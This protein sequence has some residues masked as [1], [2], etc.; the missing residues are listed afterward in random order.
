[1]FFYG[2]LT[3]NLYSICNLFCCRLGYAVYLLNDLL[4]SKGDGQ[5]I[6]FMYDI[7]CLLD[8]HLRV[9]TF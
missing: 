5:E 3:V 9:S 4:A 2:K 8:S 1:M 7:C 6:H